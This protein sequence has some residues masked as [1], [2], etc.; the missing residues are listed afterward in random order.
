MKGKDEIQNLFS[1]KLGGYEA[2]VNPELWGNIASQ[3]GAGTTAA[4]TGMALTTK[5]IIG[6]SAASVVTVASFVALTSDKEV[7]PKKNVA[8]IEV[9]E[10]T[11]AKAEIENTIIAEPIVEVTRVLIPI[12]Q[13][14]ETPAVILP[15]IGPT[16][17]PIPVPVLTPEQRVT[18]QA[19]T[20]HNVFKPQ[21]D[22]VRPEVAEAI[23]EADPVLKETP[24]EELITKESTVIKVFFPNVFTPNND[25]T[26]DLLFISNPEDLDKDG[27]VLQIV[28]ASFKTVFTSTDPNFEW[29]GNDLGGEPAKKGHYIAIITSKD[30]NGHE[31]KPVMYQFEIRK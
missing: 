19:D 17:A 9:V 20:V 7:E 12:E 5:I 3:I 31:A 16:L 4:A 25:G 30:K 15:F 13:P 27:F 22:A 24:K 29:N 10:E 21:E 1:E 14:E 8:Q 18:M 6:L 26:N 11:K 23:V 2:K 28:D